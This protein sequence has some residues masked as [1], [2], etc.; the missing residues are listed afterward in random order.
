VTTILGPQ[1]ISSDADY[2]L[3]PI[4]D[5]T[6]DPVTFSSAADL[7]ATLWRST[8]VRDEALATPAVA[9]TD[10]PAGLCRLS[11]AAADVA[12]L[13]PGDYG[14]EVVATPADGRPRTVLWATLR[15]LDAPRAAAPAWPSVAAVEEWL[16]RQHRETFDLAG[17]DSATTNGSNRDLGPPIASALRQLGVRP[18]SPL[19]PADAEL[20]SLTRAAEPAFLLACRVEALEAALGRLHAQVDLTVGGGSGNSYRL[21]QAA[22]SIQRTLD[23]LRAQFTSWYETGAGRTELGDIDSRYHAADSDLLT[24]PYSW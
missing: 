24:Y 20:A 21:S 15:L 12:P 10:A 4:L 3:G 6:G 18:A 23:R 16:I 5:S 17:M 9:W 2:D 7:A 22:S 14:V 8:G 1:S 11:V 19:R 13:A